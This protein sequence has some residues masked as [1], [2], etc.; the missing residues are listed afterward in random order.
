MSYFAEVIESSLSHFTAQAWSWE[1]FADFGSLVTIHTDTHILYGIVYD[2]QTS[3]IDPSRTPLAYKKTIEEL[4][5]DMPHIFDFLKTTCTC[6]V[7]GYKKKDHEYIQYHIP[8][9]PALIHSFVS[10]ATE[11][12]I[13]DFF[14]NNQFLHTIFNYQN[15][16]VCRDELLLSLCNMLYTYGIM[17]EQKKR[18]FIKT[19]TLLTGND[20]THL[21]TFLMRLQRSIEFNEAS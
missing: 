12:D 11:K 10:Y 2:I 9:Q 15:L 17:T 13:S 6:I 1:S 4:K 8:H 16:P 3:S 20:Y 18:S 19:L 14:A 21:K 7:V 5:R